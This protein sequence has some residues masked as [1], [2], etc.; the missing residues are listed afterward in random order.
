MTTK[1]P[2]QKTASK[3]ETTKQTAGSTEKVVD[4]KTANAIV[5]KNLE[6][7]VVSVEKK[8][9]K[10]VEAAPVQAAEPVQA[11]PPKKGGA[12]KA[13]EATP[14]QPVQAAPVQAAPAKKGGA[15]KAEAVAPVQQAQPAQTGKGKKAK[16]EA[17]PAPVQ[18]AEPVQAKKGGAKK[19]AE[20]KKEE[21]PVA[22]AAGADDEE[23]EDEVAGSKL[24]YFKLIYNGEPQGRYCGKKP[25]QAA[26]K[27]FSSIIKELKKTGEQNGGVN[28]DI[29][30]SIRE[31]T[32]NKRNKKEYKY[33][34]KRQTLTNPVKV[35]IANA[36]GSVKQIEYKFHNKLQKAPKA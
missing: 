18:A 28:V 17:A 3:S 13:V 23:G 2:K 11:T 1:A 7:K 34:G 6:N 30:F 9:K 31:C 33:I 20:P 25:K 12:K 32:R 36:D 4:V 24:R 10:A 26:N 15:K 14:V 8:G 19:A 5:E 21:A 16:Q 35:E 22:Q 29:N 27:A